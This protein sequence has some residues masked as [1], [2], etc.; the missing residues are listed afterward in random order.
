MELPCDRVDR[1]SLRC[2]TEFS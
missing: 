1:C 2:T